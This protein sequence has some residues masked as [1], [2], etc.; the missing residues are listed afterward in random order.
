MARARFEETGMEMGS[1]LLYRFSINESGPLSA[2]AEYEWEYGRGEWQTKTW[3]Y[4]QITSN[5]TYFYLHVVSVAWEGGNQI[6]HKQ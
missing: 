4:T 5:A 1:T 6:F 3:I 2:I